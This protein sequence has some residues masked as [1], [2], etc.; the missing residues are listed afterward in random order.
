LGMFFRTDNLYIGFSFYYFKG[1]ARIRVHV[2]PLIRLKAK[3]KELTGRSIGISM[4][5]RIVKLSQTIHGWVNYYQPADMLKQCQT[6]DK[7]LRHRLRMCYWKQ[8]KKIRAR[9]ENLV[10]LGVSV[11]KAWEF[12]NTKKGY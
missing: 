9:N 5:A 2:K 10:L 4:E 8:W 1:I 12:A 3:L 11:S 7:W 6:I